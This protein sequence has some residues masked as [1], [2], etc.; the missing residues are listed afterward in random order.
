MRIWAGLDLPQLNDAWSTLTLVKQRNLI[1]GVF[2]GA[3]FL[4]S[5]GP[6]EDAGGVD[7]STPGPPTTIS[8]SAPDTTASSESSQTPT[9]TAAPDTTSPASDR[10][11]APDFTLALGSG[12]TFTLSDSE[13]PVYLVFWAEW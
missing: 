1:L 4:T 3:L 6:S 11:V 7:S 13:K 12:G 5:C 2:V 10:M 9:P 8:E